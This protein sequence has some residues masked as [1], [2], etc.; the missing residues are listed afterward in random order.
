MSNTANT[1]Y[2]ENKWEEIMEAV[3]DGD[4]DEAEAIAMTVEEAGFELVANDLYK[5][6][7]TAKA[8]YEANKEPED[9]SH[10]DGNEI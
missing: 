7:A 5:A 6:I 4:F 10:A 2:L 8:D 1:N 9:Y 3:N